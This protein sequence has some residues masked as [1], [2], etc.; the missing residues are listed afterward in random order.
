MD[1]DQAVIDQARITAYQRTLPAMSS[2][3]RC[4]SSGLG[5]SP[6]QAVDPYA[7]AIR[8]RWSTLPRT[9]LLGPLTRRLTTQTSRRLAQAAAGTRRPG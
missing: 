1:P 3:C 5:P 9:A 7:L 4:A 6:A 8:T 2:K